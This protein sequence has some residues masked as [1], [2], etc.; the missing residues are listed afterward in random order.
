MKNENDENDEIQIKLTFWP[1]WLIGKDK[2]QFNTIKS[3]Q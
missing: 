2:N 1:E 3:I